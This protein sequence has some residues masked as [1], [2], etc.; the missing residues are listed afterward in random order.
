MVDVAGERQEKSTLSGVL[1]D[2]GKFDP[3]RSIYNKNLK[4]KRG[5]G[6]GP[7]ESKC[8]IMRILAWMYGCMDR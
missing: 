4:K 1:G 6:K 5:G 7:Y 3:R 8:L 2:T